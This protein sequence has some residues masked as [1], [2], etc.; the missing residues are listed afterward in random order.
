MSSDPVNSQSYWNR[1]FAEDWES[2]SGPQQ[3]L[4][5]AELFAKEVPGWL[6]RF[7]SAEVRSLCD[8][9]CAQGQGLDFLR[10]HFGIQKATGVDFSRVAVAQAAANFRECSFTVVDLRTDELLEADFI[11]CSNVLEHFS[12]AEQR[13]VLEKLIDAAR[14]ATAFLI[15]F[16]EFHRDR[17]HLLTYD[18]DGLPLSRNGAYLAF[19][20]IVDTAHYPGS[21]WFGEQ[22]LCVYVT[23]DIVIPANDSTD[24]SLNDYL[25]DQQLHF[26]R[27]LKQSPGNDSKLAGLT[28]AA[29]LGLQDL[30]RIGSLLPSPRGLEAAQAIRAASEKATSSGGPLEVGGLG[31]SIGI[32][33]PRPTM[34]RVET[35]IRGQLDRNER[36]QKGYAR[37]LAE[38]QHTM[39]L[40]AAEQRKNIRQAELRIEAIRRQDEARIKEAEA[41]VRQ[42]CQERDRATQEATE[43]NRL[44]ARLQAEGARSDRER[45]SNQNE[46]QT[47]VVTLRTSLEQVEESR[48]ELAHQLRRNE[49][50]QKG[51]ARMLAEAQH[52]MALAAAE[53]RKNIRQA[54]LRIEAIRRQDEARIKEAEAAVRQACQERDRATQE[55][56]EANRL[57]ARLQ[58]EGARSDRERD[59]N[60]NELQT[61][62]VTLRTSLEQVEESRAELAHQLRRRDLKFRAGSALHWSL[63]ALES[64]TPELLRRVVRPFYVPVYNALFPDGNKPYETPL[65]PLVENGEAPQGESKPES[66]GRR[67]ALPDRIGLDRQLARSRPKVSVVLPVWNHADLLGDSIQSVLT[68]THANL[69]LILV[70]DGSDEDLRPILQPFRSDPRL[71][72]IRI[73]HQGL[74]Q[75]LNAGFRRATGDLWTWTSAD[76]LMRPRMLETLVQFLLERPDVDM[77]FGNMDLIDEEGRP[78]V[79][80]DYRTACQDPEA[81]NCLRLPRAIEPLSIVADNFIGAAFLYRAEAARAVGEYSAHLIGVEDYDYWLRMTAAGVIEHVG[82]SEPIYSYRV[83]PRTLSVTRR[84]EIIDKVEKLIVHNQER[85]RRCRRRFKVLIARAGSEPTLAQTVTELAEAFSWQGHDVTFLESG[86]AEPMRKWTQSLDPED[87]AITIFFSA[88]SLHRFHPSGAAENRSVMHV[89]WSASGMLPSIPERYLQ[90]TWIV[91]DNPGAAAQLPPELS[92]RWSRLFPTRFSTPTELSVCVKARAAAYPL[93]DLPEFTDPLWLYLGPMTDTDV[94]WEALASLVRDGTAGTLLLISTTPEEISNPQQHLPVSDR[95]KYLGWKPAKQWYPYLSRAT[96]LLAPWADD[97]DPNNAWHDTIHAYLAAAKPILATPAIRKIGHGNAPNLIVRM[98]HEF[99]TAVA[100][101]ERLCADELAADRYRHSISPRA[102]VKRLTGA[103]NAAWLERPPASTS[104][105]ENK[106]AVRS[107]SGTR[108]TRYLIE[109]STLHRGGLERVVADLAASFKRNHID[110]SIAV[111][112]KAGDIAQECR[113]MD[114]PVYADVG[115]QT[116]FGDLLRRSAPDLLVSHFSTIGPPVAWQAGIPVVSYWHNCFVWMSEQRE[117]DFRQNDLYVSHYVAVSKAVSQNFSERFGILPDKIT[118]I[119]NGVCI[120]RLQRKTDAVA[121]LIDRTSLGLKQ[122]DFVLLNVSSFY[123]TKAQIHALSALR[124]VLSD[125]PKLRLLFLGDKGDPTYYQIVVDKIDEWGLTDHVRI[126]EPTDHIHDYYRM[127][128]G[129]VLASITEGWSLAKTEAMYFGLPMIL[130]RVGGA[131]EVV[132]S[133]DIGILI[134]PPCVELAGLTPTRAWELALNETAP[135]L[136]QLAAAMRDFYERSSFWKHRGLSGRTKVGEKYDMKIVSQEHLRLLHSVLYKH[137]GKGLPTWTNPAEAGTY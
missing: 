45:D 13:M 6:R 8:V 42:A 43:A 91:T 89:I 59:S 54:E 5:F 118:A 65:A 99:A 83:H 71:V 11:F 31:R 85:V 50:F 114:I 20:R 81:T 78:L 10:R 51:Y 109:T 18:Y 76:N 107:R 84:E 66:P 116:A 27:M 131:E 24:S 111:T 1:R 46:L 12:R 103:A 67:G 69:E 3:T 35:E 117:R 4:F 37:M 77:T 53:Q 98:P 122:D 129:F 63:A 127:A 113:Q 135:N 110:V 115:S 105:F 120:D 25:A 92:Q 29:I 2:A 79:D 130:T 33:A 104:P 38:A 61:R 73:A 62:V 100:A 21:Q 108:T 80:S 96:V 128:D 133:N 30:P 93:W 132:D 136:D 75:A 7:V 36:F 19:A 124:Q 101:Q 57:L 41:A 23:E 123:G 102:I 26:A 34:T 16:R 49:R 58:A 15:P 32:T 74:P 48:A 55:A 14:I 17:E 70:D 40:A 39:A 22:L 90:S 112:G 106:H 134:D 125:C 119:P 28:S 68:Q 52:T 56:T 126:C 44:L 87:K 121:P 97:A 9:G 86:D 47:R 95:V 72:A 137:T 64:Q 82:R 94:D 88:E 60:Q